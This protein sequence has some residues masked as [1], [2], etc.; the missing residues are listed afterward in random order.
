M[1]TIGTSFVRKVRHV[2]QIAEAQIGVGVTNMV[3]F[4]AQVG[5]HET[6]EKA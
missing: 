6:A 4:K 1:H 3:E 2:R 5:G